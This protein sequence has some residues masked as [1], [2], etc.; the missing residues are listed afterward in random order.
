MMQDIFE[1][2]NVLNEYFSTVGGRLTNK[3]HDDSDATNPL[4]NLSYSSRQISFSEFDVL[5]SSRSTT[6]LMFCL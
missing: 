3:F 2:S 5:N 1:I 6:L 4:Q